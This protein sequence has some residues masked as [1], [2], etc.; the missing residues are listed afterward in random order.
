MKK[1]IATILVMLSFIWA[2]SA[3]TG[4][5]V[6]EELVLPAGLKFGMGI[7]E[8]IAVSGLQKMENNGYR[9]T[10]ND[11]CG[12][13]FLT[14]Y[15]QGDVKIGGLDAT[16]LVQFDV[17]GLK[18]VMYIFPYSEEEDNGSVELPSNRQ[19]AEYDF[20]EQSLQRKYGDKLDTSKHKHAYMAPIEPIY[21][22]WPFSFLGITT[23]MDEAEQSAEH[24]LY[25]KTN[26]D[27]SSIYIDHYFSDSL[28]GSSYSHNMTYTYY[29]FT[30]DTN[31]ET[32]SF[33]DF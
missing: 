32:D 13:S 26:S 30:I 22:S 18:Q 3:V 21:F 12:Y 9:K 31:S 5:A 1:R 6:G 17:L 7:D 10:F 29:D 15:L 2:I 4:Y 14:E 20:I 33:I 23:W 27:G 16:I 24:T 19:I 8:A 11:T 25:L 28:E